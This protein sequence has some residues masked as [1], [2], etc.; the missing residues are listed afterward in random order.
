LQAINSPI[1]IISQD[2]NT[3]AKQ[4]KLALGF[5]QVVVIDNIGDKISRLLFPIIKEYRQ[6]KVIGREN[7]INLA[8]KMVP[9]HLDFQ[10]I[11]ATSNGRPDFGP[12]INEYVILVN[13]A[14]TESAFDA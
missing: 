9:I 11:L 14:L 13:F 6:K 10:L 4:M 12:E 5:G 8:G 3:F 7:E 1:T 2:T